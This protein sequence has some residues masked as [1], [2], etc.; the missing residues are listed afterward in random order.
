MSELTVVEGQDVVPDG[1]S[2]LTQEQVA[3]IKRTI[4]KGATNDELRLFI[5]QCNRTGLDPFARQ[6]YAIKRWDST[7]QK[8]VMGIQVS[9]DGFRLIA[10]R[11]GK[12]QG[13]LGPFWCGEDGEW[14]DAWID[15][16]PPKAAKVGVLRSDFKEPIWGFARFN[17]YVQTRRSD[18]K[19]VRQWLTMPEHMIAKC[20]EAGGLRRTF[21][22]ELSG[23]YTRD[24]MMQAENGQ[25]IE[26]VTRNLGDGQ[27]ANGAFIKGKHW[28]KYDNVRAAFWAWTGEV[29]LSHDEVHKALEVEHVEDYEF[30]MQA[31]KDRILAWIEMQTSEDEQEE[32]ERQLQ[33]EAEAELAEQLAAGAA[34]QQD[35]AI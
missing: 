25:T 6:I 11:T 12:W 4:C 14:K 30:S 9:I 22:Q 15:D 3:L 29:G 26:G 28:I 32:D 31:A 16:E 19:R 13:L 5:Q 35:M 7:E 23:L 17:S 2:R 33:T 34:N 27:P 20:A 18:G 10:D 21:P 1:Q 8:E 24:E